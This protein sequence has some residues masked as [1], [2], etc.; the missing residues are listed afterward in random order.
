MGLTIL[1]DSNVILDVVTDSPE[2]YDWS[3]KQLNRLAVTDELAINDIVYSEISPSFQRFEDVSAVVEQMGLR[4]R[5]IPRAALFLAAKVHRVYKH[6]GGVREGT[7]PDFFIGAQAAVEG[8]GLL[9][10]DV[11]RF[12][13][14]FPTLELITP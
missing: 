14:Y 1:V 4:L 6:G 12:R 11:R 7:L 13:T 5:A 9:T 8:L 2:W 3:V 10:R